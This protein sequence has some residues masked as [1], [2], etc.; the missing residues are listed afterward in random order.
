MLL[1]ELGSRSVRLEYP[2]DSPPISLDLS[3][4]EFQRRNPKPV[5]WLSRVRASPVR[6][7]EK[8]RKSGARS[9]ILRRWSAA[10]DTLQDNLTGFARNTPTPGATVPR[11]RA[12]KEKEIRIAHGTHTPK[13][14]PKI[15]T[16]LNNLTKPNFIGGA[17]FLFVF[18]C[19][20]LKVF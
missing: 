8:Q 14:P 3:A 4:T 2:T 17:K 1:N 13:Q 20:K 7:G 18:H 12:I 9:P 10:L 16:I 6:R 15:A 11:D 19:L 5:A